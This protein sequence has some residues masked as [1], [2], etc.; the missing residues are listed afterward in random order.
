MPSREV[1]IQEVDKL[2]SVE[3]TLAGAES[4]EWR[5]GRNA[6]EERCI[7]VPLE[8]GG[9]LLG[10]QLV[11]VAFLSDSKR[12]FS[13]SLVHRICVCRLDIDWLGHPNPLPLAG[14]TH[15]VR[16]TG[17]HVHTWASNRSRIESAHRL[18]KLPV[19]HPYGGSTKLMAALR[20][21]CGEYE[22]VVPHTVQLELPKAEKLI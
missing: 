7:K 13:V 4:A 3:K 2:L 8:I 16:C 10:P 5:P 22:V 15:P 11:I 19:A 1:F 9:E 21:F 14:E 18:Q 20:W 6:E 17:P 12:S